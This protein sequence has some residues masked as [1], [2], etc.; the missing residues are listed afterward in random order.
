[1][2]MQP[3]EFHILNLLL[4]AAVGFVTYIDLHAA[5][6]LSALVGVVWLAVLLIGPRFAGKWGKPWPLLAAF[7]IQQRKYVGLWTAGWLVA[8]A[9]LAISAYF[10][11]PQD[12]VTQIGERPIII[13]EMFSLGILILLALL[14]NNWSRQHIKYWKQIQ[15]SVWAIPAM[16]LIS[17]LVAARTFLDQLPLLMIAPMLL[18]ACVI[19]GL[20]MFVRSSKQPPDW[21]RFGY[22]ITG[23]ILAIGILLLY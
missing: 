18:A 8:H 21:L 23:G 19:V 11:G 3:R 10:D 2:L 7:V 6:R 5:V 1:M 9:T 22:M 4:V 15:A 14:S 13:L 16:T 17:S 12:L 20:F